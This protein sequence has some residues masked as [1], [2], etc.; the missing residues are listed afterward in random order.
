MQI[1]ERHLDSGG[2]PCA[3]TT[4]DGQHG[5]AAVRQY[6]MS[7]GAGRKETRRRKK[8]NAVLAGESLRAESEPLSW[9][10]NKRN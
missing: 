7:V 3:C 10:R 1:D 8:L 4:Q 9:A 2:D 5:V 6:D